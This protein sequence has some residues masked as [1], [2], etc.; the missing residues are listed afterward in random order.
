MDLTDKNE[1]QQ[2]ISLAPIVKTRIKDFKK[3]YLLEKKK[4]YKKILYIEY[5]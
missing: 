4:R 1:K 3:N 2:I 5:F